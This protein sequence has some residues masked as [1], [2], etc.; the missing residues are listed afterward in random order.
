MIE[1]DT[2]DVIALLAA[3]VGALALLLTLWQGRLTRRH[4]RLSVRPHMDWFRERTPGR[5]PN[6]RV[7][8]YGLGPAIIDSVT[9]TFKDKSFV[10]SNHQLSPELQAAIQAGPFFTEWDIFTP[11]TPIKA[12]HELNLFECALEKGH[13]AADHAGALQLLDQ[14]GVTIEYR[15]MYKERMT[16]VCKPVVPA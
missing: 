11:D 6:I 4:N 9:I 3:F 8:N 12:G 15:S 14:I 10:V 7:M 5:N 1:L 2:S 13:E 16:L